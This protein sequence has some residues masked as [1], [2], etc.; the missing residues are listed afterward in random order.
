MRN[1]DQQQPSFAAVLSRAMELHQTG[2]L[3]DAEI[4]YRQIL[5][6]DE[7]QF[8]ALYCLGMINAQRGQ[9]DAAIEFVDAA[10]KSNPRS[11]RAYL[12]LGH[13]QAAAGRAEQALQSYDR[14]LAIVPQFPEA[15]YG[16]GNVLQTLKRST[17]AAASYSQALA[18]T[19]DWP[20][21]LTN[22]GNALHEL[23]RYGEALRSY[24]R[25]IALMPGVAMLHNNRGNLLRDMRRWNEAFAS[26]NAALAIEPRYID[27][28]I[29]RGNIL[30]DINQP[31]GALTAFDLAL[32]LEP[33]HLAALNNRANVLRDLQRHEEAATTVARLLELVPDWDYAPGLLFQ[34]L[35]HSCDWNN[36]EQHVAQIVQCVRV[37][38]KADIPFAFLAI[39]DSASDQLQCARTY[40]ANRYPASPAPLWTG[41]RYSHDRIR[42]AYLSADLHGHATAYL[43]AGLFERHDRQRFEIT[44]ISFGPDSKD[45]MRARLQTSFDS[46]IDVRDQSDREVALLLRDREIDIAVDLKGFTADCRAG[47]FAHRPAPIQVNYLGYPGTMGADYIDYILADKWVIPVEHQSFYTE[48]VVYLPDTYQVNDCTRNIAEPAPTRKEAGLPEAGFVFCC[49]NN[50]YKITPEVFDIWMRLLARVPRSVLWLLNSNPVST[51]NLR[52]E[53]E[54]RGIA[55]ER[56]VFA[57]QV[58]VDEHL[59]RHRLADLFLDTTPYNAHTTAS[60]ALW[61]GLPVLTVAGDAFAARVAASLLDAAGLAELITH[62][63]ER[64][65]ELA[66]RLVKNPDL[67]VDIRAKLARNRMSCPL[68]D[69][70]RFRLHIESAFVTMWQRHQ[71]GEPPAGFAVDPAA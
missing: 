48:K 37:G 28:I 2:N 22:H 4:L 63:V 18:L 16:R 5:K 50:N 1:D 33:D 68:F 70:E 44:A 35:R 71:R 42:V 55:P 62:S 15:L 36:Y 9:N 12:G 20:E 29:N 65:E 41:E 30:Q 67:L 53:A 45:E 8:D 23:K 13:V 27:A 54:R 6:Q 57:P 43:M 66:L 31:E 19:P 3:A 40:T 47:I 10:V 34:S 7:R 25:A 60:D 56:L 24:D 51:R 58:R 32:S 59:A 11:A 69:T 64:Y 52:R 38:S 21:A 39:S 17:E 26:L 46:F 14:A 61:A 49:F